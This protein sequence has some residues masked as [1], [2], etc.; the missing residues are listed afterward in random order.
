ME[1]EP[2]KDAGWLSCFISIVFAFTVYYG[3]R[4]GH[5]SWGPL[6]VRQLILDGTLWVAILWWSGFANI[7]GNI[8]SSDLLYV[9][10]TKSFFPTLEYVAT[11]CPASNQPLLLLN[12]ARFQSSMDGALLGAACQMGICCLAFRIGKFHSGGPVTGGGLKSSSSAAHHA[13]LV[14]QQRQLCT[15]IRQRGVKAWLGF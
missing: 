14:R 8:K 6:W 13:L 4:S 12:F 15:C 9:P 5:G 2:G 1:F 7:P 11:S 3:M 10:I